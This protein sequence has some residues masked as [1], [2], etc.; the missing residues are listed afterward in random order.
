MFLLVLFVNSP[1]GHAAGLA[2]PVFL[3][4]FDV[5]QGDALLIHQ[6]DRCAVLIDTGPPGNGQNIGASLAEK[7][8]SHLDRL[9]ISHPHQDHFGGALSL[10]VDLTIGEVNDN[11][12]VNSQEM[13]YHSYQKWRA[14]YPYHPLKK[15]DTWQCGGV[16]C[17]VLG[18]DQAKGEPPNI[19]DTSLVLTIDV[20]SVNLLLPGDLGATGRQSLNAG[21]EQRDVNIFKVPH[22]G[23]EDR[24]LKDWLKG[25]NPELSV[26]S[27]GKDNPIGAPD[28]HTL[29]VI[30]QNSGRVWRTDR[31]GDLEIRIDGQGWHYVKP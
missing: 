5:G 13:Y 6:P 25:I 31:Q 29:E 30:R 4:F 14:K 16:V 11:G 28:R 12:V 1:A 22:H 26:V 9:I 21:A 10:P 20:G 27:V 19:N 17:T 23:A 8:I 2:G 3:T 18:P 24:H 7:G 15:G